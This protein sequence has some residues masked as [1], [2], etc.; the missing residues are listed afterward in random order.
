MNQDWRYS[1]DRMELR[2]SVF[3]CLSHHLDEHCKNVYEFCN[4]WVSQGNKTIDNIEEH[5]QN[6]LQQINEKNIYHL[7]QCLN[8]D[9]DLN[10]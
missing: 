5:F 7:R 9:T 2:A 6:Y 4:D 10:V 1:D 3:Y 8:C